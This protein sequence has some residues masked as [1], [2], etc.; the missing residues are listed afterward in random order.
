MNCYNNNNIVETIHLRCRL[1]FIKFLSV[2]KSGDD[3][4][5]RQRRLCCTQYTHPSCCA[6]ANPA[7]PCVIPDFCGVLQG[8]TRR[9]PH[10]PPVFVSL[11]VAASSFI[12]QS[13]AGQRV[14]LCLSNH[15][16]Q[17]ICLKAIIVFTSR[18]LGLALRFDSH[19]KIGKHR[20]APEPYSISTRIKSPIIPLQQH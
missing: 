3:L 8:G 5:K 11:S 2:M 6:V 12:P 13:A 14:D 4:I 16:I 10:V 18:L 1:S 7:A 15:N 17:R 9:V 19:R 20:R